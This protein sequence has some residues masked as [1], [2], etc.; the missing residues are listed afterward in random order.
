MNRLKTW[1]LAQSWHT[2]LLLMAA[3]VVSRGDLLSAVVAHGV[4]N[5]SLALYV[6]ATGTWGVW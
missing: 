2:W 4:T 1:I 6:R 5:A 3:L